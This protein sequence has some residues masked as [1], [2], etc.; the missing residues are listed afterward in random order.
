MSEPAR[1]FVAGLSAR[2]NDAAVRLRRVLSERPAGF[3]PA[4]LIDRI[5][6]AFGTPAAR[7]P[8]GYTPAS[9]DPAPTEEWDLVEPDAEPAPFLDPIEAARQAGHE[10]GLAAAR[11]EQG[12][13]AERDRAMLARL[14]E[15]LRSDARIDRERLARQLRQTVLHL[16]SRIVG[17]ADISGELLGARVSAASDLIAE[18]SESAVLRVNPADMALIAGHLPSTIAPIGD[19]GIARGSFVLEAASTIV[20][21]GPELWL[22]QLARTLDK[23]AVP[24]F[25]PAND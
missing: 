5:E 9:R 11:A 14:I 22:E 23:V 6:H 13:A 25:S 10:Q 16:V 18:A 15:A 4:D 7:Q 20:E 12:E 24:A 8:G 1:G 3:A 19:T 21:D 2:H 17:E